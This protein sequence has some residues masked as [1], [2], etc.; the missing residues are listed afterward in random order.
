MMRFVI[1]RDPIQA[2]YEDGAWRRTI[3]RMDGESFGFAYGGA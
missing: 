2:L 1:A 3:R